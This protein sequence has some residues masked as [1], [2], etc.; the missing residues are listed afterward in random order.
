MLFLLNMN[1]ELNC[2]FAKFD[3]KLQNY[4]KYLVETFFLGIFDNPSS[5]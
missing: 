5:E 1:C 3:T 2:A 4:T